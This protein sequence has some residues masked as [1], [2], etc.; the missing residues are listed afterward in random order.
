MPYSYISFFNVI[1]T[2]FIHIALIN[3]A[4]VNICRK[5]AKENKASGSSYAE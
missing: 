2:D 5:M 1:T 4:K 3:I